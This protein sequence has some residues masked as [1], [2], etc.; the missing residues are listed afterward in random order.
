M[1]SSE[2]NVRLIVDAPGDYQAVSSCHRRSVDENR[3]IDRDKGAVELCAIQS[4][5]MRKNITRCMKHNGT[6][7]FD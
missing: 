2:H 5:R 3:S 6:I 7:C 1:A 4:R